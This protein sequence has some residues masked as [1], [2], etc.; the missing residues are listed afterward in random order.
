MFVRFF[1]AIV[2]LFSNSTHQLSAII[3]TSVKLASI[4]RITQLKTSYSTPSINSV[5]LSGLHILRRS[6]LI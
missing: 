6:F 2:S 5:I 3:S 4:P 1:A